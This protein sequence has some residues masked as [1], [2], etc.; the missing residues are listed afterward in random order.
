M[1]EESLFHQALE[2]PT[3]ERAAF[4]AAAC[5][6][7]AALR[8]RVEVLLAAHS[9]PKSFLNRP[10]AEVLLTSGHMP[11]HNANGGE[12][13]PT[14]HQV[15]DAMPGTTVAGRYRLLEAIGEGGMGTVW[16]AEQRVPV[17]RLVALKLIKL[18]MAS[19]T[20]LARFE[21]ERQAL[22]LMDHP[23]IAKV[24][25]GGT[26]EDGRPY[27]VMELVRGIPLTQYCDERRLSI[28][29]RLDLFVQICQAVQHAHQKGVI[30]RDIKPTNILVTEHD[31]RPVPKVIDFGLA[32]ALQ[33]AHALT[34]QTLYTAFGAMVG[35]PLYM[36]PEQV[37]INALDVDTRSDV[38]A[39]GVILYELLTGSTPLE[40]QH[41][42]EAAWDEICRLI[43]E[44]EPPRPSVRLSSSDAALSIAAFRHT[45]PEKLGRQLRGDLDWIVLKSLE[46]DRNRRYE[47]ANGL[48][49]DIQ[50]YLAS[51][52]IMARPPTSLYRFQKLVRRNK[53]A[54]A[55]SG[56][57]LAAL[58]VGLGLST[59]LFI[60][61]RDARE[62]AV[63]A[64]AAQIRMREQAETARANEATLRQQ[65]EADEK[66]AQTEAVKSAQVAAF[67]KN[68]LQGVGPR[69]ALGR[70]TKLL[71]EILDQTAKRLDDLREQPA[72]EADL[73]STLGTVYYDLG[74][75]TSAETMHRQALE[76]RETLLGN[77]HPNVAKSLTDLGN[78]L[79]R[80]DK[81]A[82]AEMMLHKALA[83]RKKLLGDEHPDVATSLSGLAW[84][85][86]RQDKL[87]EAEAM[88]RETLA[89]RKKLLGD[90][91]PSVATS[92]ND[93]AWVLNRQGK[94]AE[95]E[96]MD[97]EALAMR[98]KLLGDEHPDVARSLD[99][100]AW[101]LEGQDK[102]AEAE[103]MHRE[104]LAMHKKLLGDEHPDVATSLSGLA[105]ALNRQNKLAEAEAMHREAL[106]MRK[107]L[108]G[109]EHLSVA[110]SLND[111]AVVLRREGKQA[112]AE[113]LINE[114]LTS[115]PEGQPPSAALL[116]V[117]ANFFG[118][119][120]RWKEAAADLTKVVELDPKTQW[121]WL[122]L[123]PLLV[124]SDN[125]ADYKKF[126]QAA[127]EQ[128]GDTDQQLIARRT[129]QCCFL[130]P[131]SG[132]LLE[133]GS[134][135]SAKLIDQGDVFQNYIHSLA[136]YR[137]GHFATAVG[138]CK[139]STTQGGNAYAEA[140][141]YLVMAMAQ[142]QLNQVDESR[143]ALAK[144]Y[145]IVDT[146]MPKLESGDLGVSWHDWLMAQ[147]LLREAK[148]LIDSTAKSDSPQ[149]AN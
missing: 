82:E 7:D 149:Q 19:K 109:A 100:L 72:V 120:G 101:V 4:I 10:A 133:G 121:S 137:Q 27:F 48:A 53:L 41:F 78:V 141:A 102:L 64:E 90:E 147:I 54:F 87:A 36:A 50:R 15:P 5:G 40:K 144:A 24:L 62:R 118:R 66:K 75:Y 29:E 38:Y 130:L 97:R 43:R 13:A 33:G 32:K 85:L 31:G 103:A 69:V 63:A 70:D 135:Q 79:E 86:N 117:R 55:A 92:L 124:E 49:M 139:K 132:A 56:A 68:M 146:R 91:H 110:A 26:T 107:K 96:A 138:L 46:K 71:H 3:D 35:T 136:E 45:E 89:M 1:T 21:A 93:L 83:M 6:A 148:Q 131:A 81:L 77:A 28:S 59:W 65:A 34:E 11:K 113:Q 30:H 98:K 94:L 17:K 119:G 52:P 123:A 106:A 44:E 9:D 23:N 134:A 25:D 39:L 122:Q 143:T 88:Q 80:Q 95:A 61:E 111:L 57:V 104:A 8:Q 51:E 105:R 74:E 12:P 60:Q 18:G 115:S 108:L 37:G 112:E 76:V 129:I 47:T 99:Y 67:M 125:L 2:K 116:R 22:A 58:V 114:M 128:F 145:E 42:K 20:V 140:K 126:C 16:M 14:S 73:R 84:V 142:Y 127:L